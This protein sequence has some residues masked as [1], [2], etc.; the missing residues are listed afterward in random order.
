MSLMQNDQIKQF[1]IAQ[2][3]LYHLLPGIPILCLAI[4][5]S[6]PFWGFGLP[7]LLA[8]MFAILFGL[9]PVQLG[10]IFIYARKQ[11]KRF[12][13]TIG[14]RNK[15]P[16]SKL[17]LWSVL[18]LL[19]CILIF[20]TLSKLEH[21]LWTVFNWIP[22]WFRLDRFSIGNQSETIIWTTLILGF[23]LN[24]ILGPLVEEI[25]FRGFLLPRMNKLGKWGPLANGILFSIYHFFTP[26]ENITRI[27]A[28]TPFI[29]AVW[30][31]KDIRIGIAVHLLLNT[32]SMIMMTISIM[33]QQ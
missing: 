24:G 28:V 6:N 11:Q 15:L 3:I 12:S 33:V 29:Y 22:E 9:I 26:W 27:I 20:M 30:H 31:N 10:I 16:T 13:E 7:I 18:L 21:Q 19:F 17:W 2:I 25:Y 5:L 8:L 32:G 1:N 14:F 23:I 4:V